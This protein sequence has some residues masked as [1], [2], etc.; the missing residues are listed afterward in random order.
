MSRLI[1]I[2]ARALGRETCNYARDAGFEVLGFLDDK[3]DALDGFVGYPPI[4]GSV[5]GWSVSADDRYV[6]ALGDSLMRAKYAAIIKKKGGEF[7]SVVHPTAYVGP[8][9]KMGD[10]CIVCPY[11]VIDCDLTM[12]RHVITNTH[13]YVAHDCLLE[14]CVTLSPNVHLG[15]RTVIRR[16]AFLGI[17]AA[18]IPD[19][20]IGESSYVAAGACVTKNVP[21]NVLVAGVPAS[22]K[23][24][25]LT[26]GGVKVIVIPPTC[27]LR[28]AG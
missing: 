3:V 21:S 11:A 7:M 10:G 8:N 1:I 6:C 17:N 19:V 12:G 16:A 18:T 13:T 27:W 15:G 23:N 28:K 26:G 20:E 25:I 9:V 2:G 24:K 14:E 5:E 22:I 4:L